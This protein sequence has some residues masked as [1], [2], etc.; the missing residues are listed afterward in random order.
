[1]GFFRSIGRAISGVARNLT[2]GGGIGG[3]L[4]TGLSALTGGGL[5]GKIGDMLGGLAEKGISKLM[6]KV[7]DFL[8]KAGPLASLAQGPLS[9]IG[10]MLSQFGQKGG[11]LGR[12]ANFAADLIGKMGGAQ[13]LPE[14]GLNNLTEMFAKTHAQNLLANVLR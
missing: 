1:M 12:L 10:G 5:G 14:A 6:G 11:F 8:G 2:S 13:N 7:S 3:L 9:M 4:K